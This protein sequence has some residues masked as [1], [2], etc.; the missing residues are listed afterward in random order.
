MLLTIKLA[1]S[2]ISP[3]QGD[4]V[5]GTLGA[6]QAVGEASRCADHE[7]DVDTDGDGDVDTDVDMDVD[8]VGVGDAGVP[9][10]L[11]TGPSL[12]IS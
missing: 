3:W 5:E 7:G 11:R 6:G 2:R 12:W 4:T 8:G 10:A 9:V 1:P